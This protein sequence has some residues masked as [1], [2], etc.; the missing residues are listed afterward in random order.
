MEVPHRP[1]HLR[2]LGHGRHHGFGRGLE[3]EHC[4]GDRLMGKHDAEGRGPGR[5]H[6]R[7]NLDR[8]L[9][10]HRTWRWSDE[11]VRRHIESSYLEAALPPGANAVPTWLIGEV[12]WHTS[13]A[14]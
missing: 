4:C 3:R 10:A 11:R 9:A 8:R 7:R 5:L 1:G 13:P 2:L 12:A 14:C 6:R